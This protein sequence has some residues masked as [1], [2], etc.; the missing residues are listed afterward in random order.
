MKT[1]TKILI[2]EDDDLMRD[3]LAEKFAKEG[4]EITKATNGEEGLKTALQIHP[5]LI[6]LDILMPKMDGLQML[7]RLR[8]DNWGAHAKTIILTNIADT[9]KVAEAMNIELE[10]PLTYLLKSSHN[11]DSI[12]EA[13]KAR[14][15]N[16]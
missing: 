8:Q 13:V 16:N 12:F 10:N 15:K 4:F 2:V 11:L 6:L 7:Q 1:S 5:D 9:E 3:S 14:L